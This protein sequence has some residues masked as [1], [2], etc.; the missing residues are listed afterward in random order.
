MDEDITAATLWYCADCST[1]AEEIEFV[2]S[3]G[4]PAQWV[5][6]HCGRTNIFSMSQELRENLPLPDIDLQS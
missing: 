5:C 2:P 3:D 6:P 1:Q 4:N